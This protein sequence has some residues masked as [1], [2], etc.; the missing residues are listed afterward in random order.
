MALT[1]DSLIWSCARY[2]TDADNLVNDVW[3]AGDTVYVAE[4]T[5]LLT[6]NVAL[7]AGAAF[8]AVVEPAD[9]EDDGDRLVIRVTATNV[10][11]RE[12]VYRS[13][14]ASQV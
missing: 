13:A 6:N 8:G 4:E 7:A 12:S 2:E 11:L 3:A 5:M 9:L 10:E 1:Y 14:Q